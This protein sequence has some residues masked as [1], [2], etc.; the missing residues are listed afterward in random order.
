MT[1]CEALQHDSCGA[2]HQAVLRLIHKDLRGHRGVLRYLILVFGEGAPSPF[3]G[4]A[5][6]SVGEEPSRQ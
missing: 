2:N 6:P 4:T 5:D 3:G 1:R